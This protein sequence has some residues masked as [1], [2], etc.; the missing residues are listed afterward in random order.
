MATTKIGAECCN[1]CIHW[2]CRTRRIVGSPPSEVETTFD[3]EKCSISHDLTEWRDCCGMFK[4]I[5]GV[6]NT[7][8]PDRDS[9][10]TPGEA[11]FKSVME[12]IDTRRQRQAEENIQHR[13]EESSL[14]T[15]E[16]DDECFQCRGRG[17]ISCFMCDGSGKG[18]PCSNCDGKGGFSVSVQIKEMSKS[19][20]RRTAWMLRTNI[21][22]NFWKEGW[23]WDKD[24]DVIKKFDRQHVVCAKTGQAEVSDSP[25]RK[26]QDILK[27]TSVSGDFHLPEGL[28]EEEQGKTIESYTNAFNTY[29]QRCKD[30]EEEAAKWGEDC[31]WHKERIRKASLSIIDTPCLAQVVFKDQFGFQRIAI[32]NVANKKVYLN[33]VSE[34]ER[35]RRMPELESEA[36]NNA[37]LQNAIGQMYGNYPKFKG[38][39]PKDVELASGW[40]MRAAK[41]GHTDA[42]D[43]LGNC[44]K[45]GDGVE[46][47]AELAAAWYAKAAKK[48]LPWG[49]FHYADVLED[50]K[51]VTKDAELA[52][53]WYL[54]AAKQGLA[55]AQWRLGCR[56]VDGRG[57]ARDKELG[58]AWKE[59][60]KANGYVPPRSSDW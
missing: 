49:Q 28:S 42:M 30:I 54:K 35:K 16:I 8:R 58:E 25:K 1:N 52:V 46:K 13:Q 33:E 21:D 23:D 15:Q 14:Q 5:R 39:V 59:R 31:W 57:T 19:Y 43:N 3:R 18:T 41:A 7:F 17:V 20:S 48:G 32:V 40:F 24:P 56:I 36:A 50:G 37:D 6:T 26:V 22:D 4:H 9:M 45:N 53:A 55:D 34:E 2:G 47:D 29:V 12:S 10:L 27:I 38:Y 51:D 44:Y 11:Y 60:A